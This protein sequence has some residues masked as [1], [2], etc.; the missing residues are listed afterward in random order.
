M[1]VGILG[2]QGAIEEHE[3]ILSDYGI[4]HLR[5]K[6]KN[7]FLNLDRLILPGGESTVMKKFITEYNLVGIY[8]KVIKS[9]PVWGICAGSIILSSKVDGKKNDLGTVDINI[10]RNGYGRQINSSIK[11]IN[12]PDLE[13]SDFKGIFIRAPKI[14]DIGKNIN[15]LA[16]KNQTPVFIQKKNIMITTFHPELTN[17]KRIYEYFLSI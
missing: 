4:S 3:N 17:D 11:N 15:V 16:K 5:I 12:I 8:K 6:N 13:I 9:I 7:D 1:N 14:I 2:F 10:I